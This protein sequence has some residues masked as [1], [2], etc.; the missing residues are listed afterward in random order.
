MLWKHCIRYRHKVKERR[1]EERKCVPSTDLGNPYE[2]GV[3]CSYTITPPYIMPT[4]VT[5]D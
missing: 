2:R 5:Q 3:A 1:G 4:T